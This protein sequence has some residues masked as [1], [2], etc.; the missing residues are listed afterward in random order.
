MKNNLNEFSNID[1][2]FD[3]L[4]CVSDQLRPLRKQFPE[5]RNFKEGKLYRYLSQR[6]N[7]L[8]ELEEKDF[9]E[10]CLNLRI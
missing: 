6:R 3:E 5:Y 2:L 10:N 7:Y 9:Q 1:D 4:A 8:I